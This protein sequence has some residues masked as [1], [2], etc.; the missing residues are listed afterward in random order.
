MELRLEAWHSPVLCFQWIARLAPRTQPCL[1][2]TVSQASPWG[3]RGFLSLVES[4]EY[5]STSK[6]R[7]LKSAEARSWVMGLQLQGHLSKPGCLLHSCWSDNL[8]SEKATYG[9]G[10]IQQILINQEAC[11]GKTRGW[12][13]RKERILSSWHSQCHRKGAVGQSCCEGWTAR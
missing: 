7:V 11:G 10:R 2:T 12:G 9:T 6:I 5:F 3:L 4:E 1:P 13:P 8:I